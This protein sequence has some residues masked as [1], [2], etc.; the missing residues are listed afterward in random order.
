MRVV[1]LG[2]N[3][4]SGK[5]AVA[6]LRTAGHEVVSASRGTGV[7]LVTGSGMGEAFKGTDIVVD[8]SN[9]PNGGQPAIDFFTSGI[10]NV[11]KH[12]KEA[13]I[14]HIVLLSI[15]AL[16]TTQ[17]GEVAP[18]YLT[19]KLRQEEVL[20]ASGLPYTIARATQ[21]YDFIEVI[22]GATTS[23][24]VSHL[25]DRSFLPVDV[26]EVGAEL[27]RLAEGKPRGIVN[28]IGP[29]RL[30]LPQATRRVFAAKGVKTEVQEDDEAMMLGYIRLK[31]DE[32]V[33]LLGG[34]EP[35]KGTITLDEWLEDQA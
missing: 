35:I 5:P 25:P 11:V 4:L 1:V 8:C 15:V 17:P 21:F 14:K 34:E 28:I 29:E 19:G 22:A 12:A 20:Q 13:G 27:A 18:G 9:G 2:G 23:S 10:T 31:G 24:G 6:A 26:G 7:D 30:T 33:V 32:L 3:G 16:P